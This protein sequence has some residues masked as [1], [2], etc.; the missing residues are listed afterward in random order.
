MIEWLNETLKS[1]A[2]EPD[3]V[4]LEHKEGVLVVVITVT[5]AAADA[6]LLA[7]RNNRLMRALGSAAALAG[8]KPR[9]RWIVKVA[10]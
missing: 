4:S 9:K 2:T 3:Q 7:G 6:G 1:L 10:G 8:A 5:L